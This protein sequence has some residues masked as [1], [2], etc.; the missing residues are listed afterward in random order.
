EHKSPPLLFVQLNYN[1]LWTK[2]IP[3]RYSKKDFLREPT[4][5]EK[6]GEDRIRA[7]PH[8]DSSFKDPRSLSQTI[9]RL[10]LDQLSKYKKSRV[11]S[12]CEIFEKN[13]GSEQLHRSK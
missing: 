4:S 3:S 8:T 5:T 13:D 9:K 10:L 12:P 7:L 2:Y 11:K 6:A 1:E